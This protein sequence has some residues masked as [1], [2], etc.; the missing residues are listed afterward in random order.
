MNSESHYTDLKISDSIIELPTSVSVTLVKVIELE[1]CQAT[2]GIEPGKCISWPGSVI[3]YSTCLIVPEII[4]KRAREQNHVKNSKIS[5][6]TREKTVRLRKQLNSLLSAVVEDG[7]GSR[8]MG[9]VTDRQ[10][11]NILFGL[12]HM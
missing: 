8:K 7:E 12:P 1:G 9:K 4:D 10:L 2:V 11:Q 6:I 5:E 3:H